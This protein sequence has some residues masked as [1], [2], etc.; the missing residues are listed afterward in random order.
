MSVY[1]VGGL[2]MTSIE[3]VLERY[4]NG[5]DTEDF[6]EQ[7]DQLMQRRPDA[8]PRGLSLHDREILTVVGVPAADLDRS[9]PDLLA[10]AG[11][12]LQA[13][14]SALSVA[15]AAARLGRSVSRVRGAIADGSL[16]G[17]KVGRYWLIPAWQL[18]G[19]DPIPHLRKIIAAIPA[20]T[21]A[22]TIDRVMTQATDEL[23]LDGKA[24]SPRDW[25]LAGN[26]P[27]A[28]IDLVA[29][30]YTW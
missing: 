5:I 3:S 20:G 1:N 27:A 25:L 4:G 30:L 6:A 7:L 14:S 23:Y 11:Q 21:S 10:R 12:L 28:V 29:Q 8:D 15:A 9:G 26:P 18:G 17:N 19:S 24:V 2:V 13:S 16:Y 22:M